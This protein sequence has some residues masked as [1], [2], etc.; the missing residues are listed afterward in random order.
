LK[1]LP[2]SDPLKKPFAA[3][4]YGV[5][6]SI[7][8]N[9]EAA[10][11]RVSAKML[12]CRYQVWYDDEGCFGN[13]TWLYAAFAVWFFDRL[14]RVARILKTGIRRAKV[15][16]ISSTIVRIDIPEIRWA[17]P[18]RCVY[19]YSPDAQP[20]PA[21]GESSIFSNSNR[22][23]F[24]EQI[25]RRGQVAHRRSGEGQH[26]YCALGNSRPQQGRLYKLGLDAVFP[27]ES[28]NSAR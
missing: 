6:G 4:A 16:N 18:G 20:S 28:R 5:C 7:I 13:E 9:S 1:W 15:T 24:Q 14:A 19:V 21:M 12:A 17:A 10:T 27:Q 23:P 11:H 22:N 25:Q 3:F 26:R 8:P 2:K